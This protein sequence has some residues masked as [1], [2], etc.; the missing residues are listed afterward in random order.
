VAVRCERLAGQARLKP[1][2]A[3]G[4]PAD[5]DARARRTP[6]LDLVVAQAFKTPRGGPA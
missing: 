3:G 2:D 4:T 1:L 5:P 6:G